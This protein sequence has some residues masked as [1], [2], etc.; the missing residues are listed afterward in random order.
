MDK[1]NRERRKFLSGFVA[2]AAASVSIAGSSVGLAG[3]QRLEAERYLKRMLTGFELGEVFYDDWVLKA[4]YP[5]RAGAVILN[6]QKNA[7]ELVRIDVC[8]RGE[9]TR[10]PAFTPHLELYIMDGG[11][12]KRLLPSEMIDALQFLADVLQENESE[13]L[14]ASELL[15]H[16]ER[17]ELFPDVM[18]CAAKELV[19]TPV[20]GEW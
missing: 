12:G 1:S 15:T 18:S 7:G 14:L 19:P 2:A 3:D 10:A 4:A 6:I 20:R 8:R 5:P 16:D 17:I 11:G 9:V 13:W